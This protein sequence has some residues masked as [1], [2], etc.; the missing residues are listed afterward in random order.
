MQEDN[1]NE[2]FPSSF[3]LLAKQKKKKKKMSTASV[4]LR[5]P[6]QWWHR[7]QALW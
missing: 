3:F 4:T 6:L 2:L 7:K 5:V 1:D